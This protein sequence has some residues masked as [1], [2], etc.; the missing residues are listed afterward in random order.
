MASLARRLGVS[1]LA[2]L[3][4]L[5][6]TLPT[7]AASTQPFPFPDFAAVD[8]TQV[9]IQETGVVDVVADGD[10][11]RFI[12]NGSTDYM[13]VRLLGINTP[14]V[15]GF[16]NK[17]RDE[18]MCGAVAATDLLKSLLPPGWP[19][20]LR[21]LNKGSVGLDGRAQRYA[22]AWNPT[23]GLYDTDVQAALSQAGLAMWFTLGHEAALSYNYRVLTAQAQQERR[24]I[25]NPEFCGPIEQP[26]ASLSVIAHWNAAGNDNANPNGE[27]VIVRNTGL[28]PVDISGWLLR[29]SSLAYWFNFPNGSVL[30]PQDYR[31]VHAGIGN[32]GQPNP[33]DLYMGSPRALFANTASDRFMGDGAYL[34]DRSTAMRF[35]FEWPC[36]LDCTDPAQGKL[37]IT[38]VNPFVTARKPSRAANQEYIVIR[39]TSRQEINLDGYYLSYLAATYPFV[40]DS[41]I[42]PGKTLTVFIGKGT[43]TRTTQFWGRSRTLLRDSGGTVQLLSER[44]VPISSKSW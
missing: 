14:E 1:F 20:Q 29:D 36:V 7:S 26:N 9:P 8:Y 43:P 30:A 2:L 31:V 5:V 25:W 27:Y 24:G 13:T 38:K 37:K 33:R 12:E 42:K 32:P 35:W 3:I 44:N 15:R 17:N 18:D 41:R 19:V 22:F 39:N 11:I 28:E 6:P 21:S 34:L 40:V 16:Y 10:T 4:T 23:T